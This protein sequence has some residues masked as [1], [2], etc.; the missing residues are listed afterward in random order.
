[1]LGFMCM[2][3]MLLNVMIEKYLKPL[4]IRFCLLRKEDKRIRVFRYQFDFLLVSIS[5]LEITFRWKKTE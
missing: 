1:M 4:I 2:E 5:I 3:L